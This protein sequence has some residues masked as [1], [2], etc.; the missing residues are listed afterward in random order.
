VRTD[1]LPAVDTFRRGLG[2]WGSYSLVAGS[3]IGTGIFFFVAPVAEQLTSAAAI[4]TAWLVGTL[5]ASTGALCLA[6]LAAADPRTGGIYVFLR[7]AYGPTVAFLYAWSKFLIMRVGSLAIAALAFASFAGELLA[8]VTSLAPGH[9]RPIAL[10]A[11][12][13]LAALNLR[14][15][16]TGGVV[17]VVLTV[18]KL[19]ALVA[20]LAVGL[21]FGLGLLAPRAVELRAFSGTF[22]QASWP[23]L[24]ALV[25]VM[26]TLGGWDE[27]P[28]VAEEV[29]EP[30]RSLPRSILVGL[31]T[32]GLLFVLVNASYLAILTPAELAASGT[33]TATVAMQRALGPGAAIGLDAALMIS[34]FGAANG[35][36]LTGARLGYAAGKDNLLLG[37][38]AH[39]SR[40]TRVPARA[41]VVQT[42]LAASAVLIMR[43][44]FDL[45]LYTA[46]SYWLFAALMAAAVVVL[47][48]RQPRRTRP[49][50]VWGYPWTP[51]AFVLA[52]AAM[53][54]SAARESTSSAVATMVILLVGLVVRTLESRLAPRHANG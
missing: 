15:V 20:V 17:Q 26:W 5:I 44:P 23:M 39:L 7:E 18:A 47:R 21:A 9:D 31:W 51:A 48:M 25:P 54:Y 49:F 46:V 6:E 10:A 30:E 4:L 3:M 52:A 1:A 34:T 16:R 53:A 33:H 12:G 42:A 32:V 36:M 19:L 40:H 37:W 13:A 24:A 29:R 11:I 35:M 45:L 2:P 14:G 41:L 38:L 27:S 43:D 22:S 8:A 28:F 50:A